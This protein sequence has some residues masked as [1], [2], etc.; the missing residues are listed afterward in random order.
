MSDKTYQRYLKRY[1]KLKNKSQSGGSIFSNVSQSA[2][3]NLLSIK[4]VN[5]RIN[6]C[7][8]EQCSQVSI[9][10]APLSVEIDSNVPTWKK[11]T[12]NFFNFLQLNVPIDNIV[13]IE[14]TSITNEKLVITDLD[15]NIV[16]KEYQNMIYYIDKHNSEGHN[17]NGIPFNVKVPVKK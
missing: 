12:E 1:K 17:L 5:L 14:L 2:G 8:E 10:M 7:K 13:K 9:Q 11:Y 3:S 16:P 15:S 6:D 4:L